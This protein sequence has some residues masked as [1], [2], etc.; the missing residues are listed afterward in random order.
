MRYTASMF[1]HSVVGPM[2]QL[3]LYPVPPL[4]RSRLSAPSQAEIA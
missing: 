2:L 3:E 1:S 4:T